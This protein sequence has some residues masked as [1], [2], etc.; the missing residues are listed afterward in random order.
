VI[1][2]LPEAILAGMS[3]GMLVVSADRRL[4]YANSSASRL[5][6]VDIAARYGQD[7]DTVFLAIARETLDSEATLAAWQQAARRVEQQPRLDL[8]FGAAPRRHIVAQLFPA[9]SAGGQAAAFGIQLHEVTAAPAQTRRVPGVAPTRRNHRR[10]SALG[11]GLRVLVVD[12]DSAIGRLV[13]LILQADAHRV[14]AVSSGKEALERLRVDKFD[15]VL[16]DLGMGLGIDGLE[17]CTLVRRAWPGVRFVLATGSV[18]V[19]AGEAKALGVDA[20]LTKPFRPAD[21]RQII[22]VPGSRVHRTRAA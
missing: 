9:S 14:V 15:V 7:I 10:P 12:D 19:D 4:Q 8:S 17:L 13:T 22:A 1:G 11:S 6:G 3:D 5:V 20:L 16:S 2:C 21:L 18:S